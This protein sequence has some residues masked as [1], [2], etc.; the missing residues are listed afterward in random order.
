MSNLSERILILA[1]SQKDA[2]STR[3]ILDF[4]KIE[5][6][7]CKNLEEL[8]YEAHRGAGAVILA[9]EVIDKNSIHTLTNFFNKQPTWSFLPFIIL[10][11]AGDLALGNIDT[12]KL[13]KPL[14]NTT[15][16]ERPVRIGTLTSVVQSVIADRRRQYEVRDLL[17]ALELSKREAIE[18]NEAKSVFLA[19]MS[20][21]IRTPLGAILGFTEFLTETDLPFKEHSAYMDIIQRN[22]KLLTALIDDILDLAKV[23]SGK[24]AIETIGISVR[25]LIDEIMMAL[26]PRALSKEIP[27]ILTLEK[28]V[29]TYIR[30]DP[31][32]FKQILINVIGNA[33]K[34]TKEGKINIRIF[35][36]DK[37]DD[38]G[39]QTLNIEVTDTGVGISSAQ[40]NQLFQPFTQA[41]SSI[42]RKFGG[43][44]LGLVLSKK[45]ARALGGDLQL[46]KSKPGV[47]SQFLIS[48]DITGSIEEHEPVNATS[49]LIKN[50]KELKPLKNYRILL[51]DDSLD[52]QLLISR[53]LKL[54]GAEVTIASDGVEGVENAL[55]KDFDV[56][57]M[58]IQM[59]RLGGREATQQ[60]RQKGFEKPIIA[61]TAHALKEDK[62]KCLAI[63]CNYYLTKPIQRNQLIQTIVSCSH[64]H[65]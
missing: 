38:D 56:V 63:G 54:S 17:A 50:F 6:V 13:L 46:V 41:D 32:R 20:H 9:K 34:F 49:H 48:I 28:S 39:T 8:L 14:R 18:A 7:K 52:N 61:L 58:D 31:I 23:E 22:G 2:E 27:L 16:L 60:L 62:D 47:G 45:L 53:I 35:A 12:L 42:T 11:G 15:L 5:S 24:I 55:S 64:T 19:N 40:V 30:T 26:E 33:I 44:G 36:S 4:S 10:I 3:Q 21:E 25:D 65:N 1:P 59:P 43:T 51:V 37:S 57:L 29:P